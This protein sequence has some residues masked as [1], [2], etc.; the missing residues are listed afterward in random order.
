[1]V[2][3][4]AWRV[5]KHLRAT[6]TGIPL[7]MVM[8]VVDAHKVLGSVGKMRGQDNMV[9]FEEEDGHTF[10]TAEAKMRKVFTQKVNDNLVKLTNEERR[11]RAQRETK[12]E[13][14]G[15]QQC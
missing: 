5:K 1:M 6:Q 13:E 2:V 4:C 8:Q 12:S 3:R 10:G 15:Q 14:A 9:A 11:S 7:N